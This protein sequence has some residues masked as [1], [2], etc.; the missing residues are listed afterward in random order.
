MEEKMRRFRYITDDET[1]RDKFNELVDSKNLS[2]EDLMLILTTIDLNF[3][4]FP[5]DSLMK[6]LGIQEL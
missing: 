3:D 2:R 6:I 5:Q 1:K 4:I